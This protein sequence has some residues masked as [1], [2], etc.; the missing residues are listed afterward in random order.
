MSKIAKIKQLISAGKGL[1]DSAAKYLLFYLESLEEE[2]S[3]RDGL[4]RK[5][6]M[7]EVYVASNFP[8]LI[9]ERRRLADEGHISVA[10]YKRLTDLARENKE[11]VVHSYKKVIKE[12]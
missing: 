5:K 9:K 11:P 2:V 4:S 1:N 10:E 3:E 7:T 6:D 8:N 12:E